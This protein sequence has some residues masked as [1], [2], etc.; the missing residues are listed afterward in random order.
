M[1]KRT[2]GRYC[3]QILVG[4]TPD[5]KRKM[6]TVYGKTIKEV[7]LKERE[8]KS[9][10]EAGMNVVDKITV[11]EWANN[12]LETYKATTSYNTYQV[13][14][15]SIKNHINPAIGKTLV[16]NVKTIQIQKLINDIIKSGRIRTAEICKQTIKQFMRQAYIEGLVNRDVTIGIQAIKS[17]KPEKRALTHDEICTIKNSNLNL[18][19]R[20]FLNIMLYAGLRRGEAL[21][22]TTNNIDLINK[23][24]EV[25]NSLFFEENDP[26]IKEPK[27]KSS[28][29]KIPIPN[30]LF[31]DLLLYIPTLA[32]EK[33][34]TMS[35]GEYMTK[36]SFRKFWDGIMKT[37]NDSDGYKIDFTPHILRHTYA[38]NLYY[39]GVDTKSAQYFLGHSSL[40][41]TLNVYT[42]L[43]KDNALAEVEKINSFI[44][45]EMLVK[46]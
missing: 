46:C 33:L 11:E 15:V 30:E 4:Y 18:K 24:I 21:A 43:D 5:G 23:T 3:K 19:Q 20:T 37:I 42:H 8:L 17:K 7:E 29:R 44:N 39:A 40:E 28:I 9:K 41:M 10:I 34:F 38:T 1:K 13:Y 26:A 2:D 36:S 22:M 31:Q 32:N 27:T 45:E 16:G 35:N 12:W 25:K 14:S 6:K